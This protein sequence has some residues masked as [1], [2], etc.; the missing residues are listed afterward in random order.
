MRKV[1]SDELAE[2]QT[3]RGGKDVIRLTM[4]FIMRSH[5]LTFSYQCKA[6]ADLRSA[7]F[8]RLPFVHES[9]SRL[10]APS[11]E[12][13]VPLLSALGK[14]AQVAWRASALVPSSR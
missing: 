1:Y 3:E 12:L 6:S 7:T 10:L 5:L 11:G 4:S 2:A 8:V 14:D 13:D 9:G